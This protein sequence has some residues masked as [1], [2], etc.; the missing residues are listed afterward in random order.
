MKDEHTGDTA[1]VRT[2][3]IGAASPD[4][5]T[6]TFEVVQPEGMAHVAA[7]WA[8][9][10]TRQQSVTA[11]RVRIPRLD[12]WRQLTLRGSVT[13]GCGRGGGRG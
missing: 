8:V 5:P 4:P 1:T 13:R 12:S 9:E 3:L 11:R 6:T 7:G 10:T 2:T